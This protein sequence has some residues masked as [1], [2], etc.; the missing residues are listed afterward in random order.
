MAHDN[1][2]DFAL[3]VVSRLVWCGGGDSDGGMCVVVVC[4]VGGRDDG[5]D[6]VLWGCE[7]MCGVVICV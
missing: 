2:L 1:D 6:F 3:C 4:V 7:C 5:S